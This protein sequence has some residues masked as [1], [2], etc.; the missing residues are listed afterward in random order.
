MTLLRM[1]VYKPAFSHEESLKIL[2]DGRGTQFDPG[3]V[4]A[5]D[6]EENI[7]KINSGKIALS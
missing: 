2:A 3:V 4:D 6:I 5:F 7:R 1:R